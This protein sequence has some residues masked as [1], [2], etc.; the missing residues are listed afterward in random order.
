MAK[1]NTSLTPAFSKPPA[2]KTA[3]GVPAAPAAPAPGAVSSV[4]GK[5]SN[6]MKKVDTSKL[7]VKQ[8][9]ASLLHS[10]E[11]MGTLFVAS[12]AE[13][14]MGTEKLKIGGIDVRAPLGLAAQAYGAYQILNGEKSGQHALALGT[15]V[16]GSL[17]ASMGRDAGQAL[18]EKRD[19]KSPAPAASSPAGGF[20][21][22][23]PLVTIPHDPP[24]PEYGYVPQQPQLGYQAPPPGYMQW[25]Q[26]GYPM[27]QPMHHPLQLG[28]GNGFPMQ[29]NVV[30]NQG[31]GY[32][33][34]PQMGAQGPV[35]QHPM[36][37]GPMPGYPHFIQ[38][39]PAPEDVSSVKALTQAEGEAHPS[40]R[41]SRA[42]SSFLESD[43][44]SELKASLLKCI[45]GAGPVG[46]SADELQTVLPAHSRNELKTY[47]RALKQEGM[48][49]PHGRTRGARWVLVGAR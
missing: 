37:P 34:Q 43:V 15:G 17:L 19:G 3:A 33:G 36:Q 41:E 8:T 14:Y 9:G 40:D 28:P 44:R 11:T 25:P 49:M 30:Q 45:A 22:E 1:D 48:I 27:H 10:T 35:Y 6:I 42:G 23:S 31:F 39:Q 47:L 26:Q 20:R 46:A 7:A 24:E 12:A 5:V 4:T 21:G 38:A 16:T 32:A 18:R 2:G 13:G 29:Q